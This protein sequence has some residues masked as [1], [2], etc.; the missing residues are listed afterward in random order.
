MSSCDGFSETLCKFVVRM[1]YSTGQLAR[2]GGVPKPTIANWINGRVSRPRNRDDILRLAAVLHLNVE[3]ASVLLQ[4]A[5]YPPITELLNLLPEGEMREDDLLAPWADEVRQNVAHAP[6]QVIPELPYFVPRS[7]LFEQ[8][9]NTILEDSETKILC[10]HGMGGTGKTTLAAHLAYS[11]RRNFPDGVLWASLDTSDSMAI[12]GT[13]AQAYGRDVKDYRDLDSRSRVVR[14]LLAA[15]EALIVLD[16]ASYS[17]EIRPLL[18]PSGKCTVIITT[19]RQDLSALSGVK[20]F[21]IG[22]FSRESGESLALFAKILGVERIKQD[23][24]ALERIADLLGH[25]PL[26]VSIVACRLAYEPD[27]ST[28]ELLERISQERRRLDT[29]TYEDLN[30]CL[31]FNLSYHSLMPF[32]KQ[33]FACLGVFAGDAFRVE[34]AAAVSQ[35]TVQDAQDCLRRLFT[36]SLV[37]QDKPGYYRLHPLLYD[38]AKENIQD[39]EVYLRKINYFIRYV[40][41]NEFDHYVLEIEAG[42]ISRSIKEAYEKGA[43]DAVICGANKFHNF[44][45]SRG[46]YDLDETFLGWAE[47][48]ARKLG[49]YQGLALTLYHL[50]KI[51]RLRGE[52]RQAEKYQNEGHSLAQSTGDPLLMLMLLAAQASLASLQGDYDCSVELY[53]QSLIIA[54]RCRYVDSTCALL[55]DLG[56]VEI[57]RGNF[58]LAQSYYLEGL[59]LARETRCPY[60]SSLLLA[61]LADVSLILGNCRQALDYLKEGLPLAHQIGHRE[62]IGYILLKLGQVN[63]QLGKSEAGLKFLQ[64]SLALARESGQYWLKIS[65]YNGWGEMSLSQGDFISAERFFQESLEIAKRLDIQEHIGAALYGLSRAAAECGDLQEAVHLSRESLSVLNSIQHHKAVEVRNWLLGNASVK[66]S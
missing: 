39:Q 3:E 58:A 35:S 17:R 27:W 8:V 16:N 49:D 36:L 7:K 56:E 10:L 32:E 66:T 61:N 20:R 21:R 26:A 1:G 43:W 30:V 50:G 18:P 28:Q 59:E 54:R 13:F 42:H 33:F 37:Q 41:T 63:Y 6:F 62:R 65:V 2:L 15:K 40:E 47:Q 19:R 12:L 5:G 14:E 29:L 4:S 46:D 52:Y 25:L 48:S 44:L 22:S 45:E 60:N 23:K 34:A 38:Y 24:I 57:K 53:Q 64:E 51:A 11:L 55:A 9:K 31:S